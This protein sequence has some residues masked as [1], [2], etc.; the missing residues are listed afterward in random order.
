MGGAFPLDGD[1]TQLVITHDFA[2]R[3]TDAV[4]SQEKATELLRAAVENNSHADLDAV[5]KEAERR[6]Q[7]VGSP[8]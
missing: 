5:R 3:P 4:P 2:A 6:V 8:A 1:H 7:A